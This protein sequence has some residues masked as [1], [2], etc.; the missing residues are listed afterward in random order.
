MKNDDLARVTEFFLSVVLEL[1]HWLFLD[2]ELI[3]L[4]TRTIPSS[5]LVLR[6]SNSDWN[7]AL[8]GLQLANSPC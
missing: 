1:G 6:T 2:L 3:Q 4:W 8:L 7:S 5:L